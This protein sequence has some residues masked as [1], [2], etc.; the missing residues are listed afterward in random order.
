MEL[1]DYQDLIPMVALTRNLNIPPRNLSGLDVFVPFL[2]A[3]REEGAVI[4]LRIYGEQSDNEREPY[5]V[6]ISRL[7]VGNESLSV[8]ASSI[9][10][11]LSYIIVEYARRCWHFEE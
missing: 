1:P 11:A 2:E 8:V 7:P 6:L 5:R 3:M 10:E 4:N 9:E